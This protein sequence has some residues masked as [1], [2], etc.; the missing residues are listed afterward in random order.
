MIF[1]KKKGLQSWETQ[2][3]TILEVISKKKGLQAGNSHFSAGFP[4]IFAD[5]VGLLLVLGTV[6]FLG[7]KNM[8]QRQSSAA[9]SL[10]SFKKLKFASVY[11]SANLPSR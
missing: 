3:S 2:N 6:L 10:F 7:N 9:V 1:K 5:L 8:V 11:N 4:Q